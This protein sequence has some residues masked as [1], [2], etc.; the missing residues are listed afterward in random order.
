M[1]KANIKYYKFKYIFN[2]TL[3]IILNAI[4]LSR[5]LD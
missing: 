2:D 3:F 4:A 5:L 1:K